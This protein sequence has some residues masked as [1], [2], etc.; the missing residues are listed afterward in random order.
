MVDVQIDFD[1]GAPRPAPQG[2]LA[3]AAALMSAKGVAAGGQRGRHGRNDLGEAWA[4]LGAS[5]GARPGA[6]ASSTR[7]ARSPSPTCWSAPPSWRAPDRPA[8]FPP[9]VWA[10]SASAGRHHQSPTPAPGPVAA[11]AFGS[12]IYGDHPMARSDRETLARIEVPDLQAF[13]ER[14]PPAARA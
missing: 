12:A 4:D 10:A 5:F 13:H 11:K 2:C 14:M 8:S 7:C 3:A 6:T 1:A 9:A